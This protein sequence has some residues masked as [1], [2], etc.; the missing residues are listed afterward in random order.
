MWAENRGFEEFCLW[1]AAEDIRHDFAFCYRTT[2]LSTDGVFLET[3]TP[4]DRGVEMDLTFRLPGSER[5]IH[6]LGEV[7][8]VVRRGGKSAA[9]MAVKFVEMDIASRASLDAYLIARG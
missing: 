6:V 7:V 5:E 1:L 4:L 3:T 8:R 9:G 2:D